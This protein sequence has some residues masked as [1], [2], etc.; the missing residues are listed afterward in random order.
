[1]SSSP[2]DKKT[3]GQA[4]TGA[5]AQDT[6]LAANAKQNQDFSNQSRQSLFGTYSPTTGTYSGGT[7]SQFLDPSA[8]NQT[9]LT[10]PYLET[11]N[12]AANQGAATA[13]NGVRTAMQNAANNG[14]GKMP[15][16]FEADQQRQAYNDQAA[17]NGDLYSSVANQQHSDALSNY[18]NA[19]NM[20]NSNSTGTANLSLQG[21]QAAANNYSN[22]YG[23]A[24]QQKA[25]PWMQLGTAAIGGASQ[26]ASAY[27]GRQ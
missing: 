12:N 6:Q 8:L 16:G 24:S 23:T 10:G 5:Q 13:Q 15:S 26:V 9:N 20:L 19:T 22:L 2:I 25:N 1:M 4:S 17:N 21:N 14:M 3:Q 27:A 18:W 7:E 11:Y